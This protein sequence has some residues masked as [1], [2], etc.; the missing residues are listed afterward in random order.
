MR[1]ITGHALAAV[2][3]LAAAPIAA[4]GLAVSLAMG[5]APAALA[6]SAAQSAP[7]AARLMKQSGDWRL[8]L[9]RMTDDQSMCVA[10]TKTQDGNATFDYLVINRTMN[11]F[12]LHGA[13]F[14][15]LPDGIA[16][17]RLQIDD[18]APVALRAR[19]A[20]GMVIMPLDADGEAKR[21][22]VRAM[23]AGARMIA[24]DDAGAAVASYSLTGADPVLRAFGPCAARLPDGMPETAR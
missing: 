5:P 15:G 20:Q 17:F 16:T 9:A 8:I 3:R 4:V 14:A 19:V 11:A 6:Q 7:Q 1:M 13:A 10:T 2:L 23:A 18:S 22:F 24:L 21:R 12:R